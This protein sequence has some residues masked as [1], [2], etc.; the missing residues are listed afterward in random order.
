MLIVLI[1]LDEEVRD[2]VYEV[3]DDDRVG[4]RVGGD[5]PG[6]GDDPSRV[7]APQQRG[8]AKL[9]RDRR[10]GSWTTAS[11]RRVSNRN[12]EEDRKDGKGAPGYRA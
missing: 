7:R 3:Y 2:E 9:R 10:P 1:S 6:S 5:H 8:D 11:N 4:G 12:R